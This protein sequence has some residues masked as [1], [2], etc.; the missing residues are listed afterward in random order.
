M[1]RKSTRINKKS[2][3]KNKKYLKNKTTKKI[4]Q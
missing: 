4:N 2:Y 1:K 3:R